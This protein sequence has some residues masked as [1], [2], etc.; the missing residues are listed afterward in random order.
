MAFNLQ[1][2]KTRTLTAIV[3]VVVMSLGL[4]INY[5]AYFL[6][7]TLIHIGCWYEYQKLMALIHPTYQSNSTIHKYS[8]IIGGIGFML[9]MSNFQFFINQISVQ[10]IGYFIFISALIITIITTFLHKKNQLT[11]LL[12]SLLGLIY[13]T[14]SIGLLISLY[15]ITLQTTTGESVII[16]KGIVAIFIIACMWVNDTMAYIVGSLIGK[17]PFSKISPKKTWEG[18]IGGIILCIIAMGLMMNKIILPK[19]FST[20]IVEAISI[21]WYVIAAI[22]AIF[23]LPPPFRILRELLSFQNHM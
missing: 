4:F 17:T 21:H 20:N 18:T 6:L 19:Y 14:L 5:T 7:F 9:F 22:A 15:Q 10:K 16:D 23:F 12:N 2:F 11:T 13:I 1:T 3:F 8:I